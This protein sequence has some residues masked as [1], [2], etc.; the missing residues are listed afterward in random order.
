MVLSILPY[1]ANAAPN[2]L[3]WPSLPNIRSSS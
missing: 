1:S 2:G 3:G